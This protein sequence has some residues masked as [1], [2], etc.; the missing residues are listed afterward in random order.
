[1]E[2][3]IQSLNNDWF[4]EGSELQQVLQVTE[5][6]FQSHSENSFKQP[7]LAMLSHV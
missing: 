7:Q 1:M 5:I 4:E 2:V 3:L 6:I